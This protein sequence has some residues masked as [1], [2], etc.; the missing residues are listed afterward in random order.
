ML[1]NMIQQLGNGGPGPE[2][3]WRAPVGWDFLWAGHL[4]GLWWEEGRLALRG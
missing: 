2:W 3:G 1:Q 4:H